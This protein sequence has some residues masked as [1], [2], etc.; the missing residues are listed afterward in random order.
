MKEQRNKQ[1]ATAATVVPT[2]EPLASALPALA[3]AGRT[4]VACF[5]PVARLVLA[6][7]VPL[8]VALLGCD[9]VLGVGHGRRGDW[10]AL[11][12]RT[13]VCGLV[14]AL[15][16]PALIKIFHAT[17]SGTEP[18]SVQAA[19]AFGLGRM[20]RS[21][22][23]RLQA[24]SYVLAGTLLLVLPGFVLLVMGLLIDPI[25]ALEPAERAVW[26]RSR[27]LTRGMRL[28]AGAAFAVLVLAQ[29]LAILALTGLL[30]RAA[31][32]VTG[33]TV[34]AA[35]SQAAGCW[36]TQGPGT[37]V[38]VAATKIIV[39]GAQ[40]LLGALGVALTYELYLAARSPRRLVEPARVTFWP[41]ALVPKL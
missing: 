19:L 2:V 1:A 38:S 40:Q 13:L 41:R 9:I 3:R 30:G 31:G 29:M 22:G 15:V 20:P 6:V 11:G 4:Y 12:V 5:G 37:L 8:E 27:A 24:G 32:L 17:R 36:L 7:Y 23:C 33:A 16:A 21:L 26:A 25:V 39:Q 28:A 35:P 34:A 10:L 14:A 18:P